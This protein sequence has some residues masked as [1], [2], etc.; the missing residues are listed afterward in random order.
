[1]FR[2]LTTASGTA[3]PDSS[4]TVPRIVPR[5][6]A[7]ADPVRDNRI[8]EQTSSMRAL[9]DGTAPSIVCDTSHRLKRR[10][11]QQARW[12]RSDVL[13]V[14][15]GCA[16]LRAPRLSAK[17]PEADQYTVQ[18]LHPAGEPVKKNRAEK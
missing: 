5:S 2:A 12:N 15:G 14:R 13:K 9:V 3:A 10:T 8:I 6:C 4:L 18:I 1:M 11:A 17:P 7:R 16:A